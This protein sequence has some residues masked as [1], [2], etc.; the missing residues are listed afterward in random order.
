MKRA[1]RY[2]YPIE[3]EN[4]T[5]FAETLASAQELLDHRFA[6]ISERLFEVISYDCCSDGSHYD[7]LLVKTVLEVYGP[8]NGDELNDG[9]LIEVYVWKDDTE[10]SANAKFVELIQH[11]LTEFPEYGQDQRVRCA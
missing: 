8:E 2:Y 3:W 6:V 4:D 7:V 11:R 10:R 9:D 1:D 5:G